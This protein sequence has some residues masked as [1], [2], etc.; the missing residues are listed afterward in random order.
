MIR[1]DRA[2]KFKGGLAKLIKNTLSFEEVESPKDIADHEEV[3]A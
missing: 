1:H 3:E 2:G